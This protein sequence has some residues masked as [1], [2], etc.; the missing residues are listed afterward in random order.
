ME[1][2]VSNTPKSP[3]VVPQIDRILSKRCFAVFEAAQAV[4]RATLHVALP[5]QG[6]FALSARGLGVFLAESG[7]LSAFFDVR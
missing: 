2:A 1:L 5:W 6:H 3:Q 7:E 4:P